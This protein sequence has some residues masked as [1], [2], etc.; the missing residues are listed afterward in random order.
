MKYLL[1]LLLTGCAW[2][3][4]LSWMA[5]SYHGSL[6]GSLLE[7]SWTD[8][9]SELLGTTV[10]LENGQISLREL[11]RVRPSK[12][13]YQLDLW[14]TFADGKSKH[15]QMNG[16]LEGAGRLVFRDPR[17]T[18]TFQSAAH[19]G[20]RVELLKQTLSV[21]DLTAG[22]FP[23]ATLPSSGRYL[24]HTYIGAHVFADELSWTAEAGTLTVP[25]KFSSPLEN[26]KPIP[27]GMSFEI[28]V[29]EGQ[30]P[31]RV[32]YQLHFSADRGQAIG[33]LVN[34]STGRTIGSFVAV[35]KD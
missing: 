31:Y 22:P 3:H 9:G 5:G 32:R 33:T 35:K 1:A 10:W 15:L 26:R 19:G 16:R 7:E 23:V 11:A 13:G 20:L 6:E 14:L 34:L 24:L 17:T 12:E 8:T 29:P 25:G 27:G 30:Q 18:L 4:P 28:L 2:A 21:F